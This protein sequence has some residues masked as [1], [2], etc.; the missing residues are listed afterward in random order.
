MSISGLGPVVSLIVAL[1]STSAAARPLLW[2]TSSRGD[3]IYVY[4]LESRALV[5]RLVVGPEPHGI[6]A[7]SDGSV[8][9]VSLEA[10]DRERGELVWIDPRSLEILHRLLVGPEPHQI[11]TTPDGRFVYVPC[12]DGNYWVVDARAR[13]VLKRIATGGRPHN[14]SA[15]AD[16]R[17][18]LLSPMGAPHRVTVVD[19]AAGH[20]VLGEIAFAGSLRPPALSADGRRLFQHVDAL[21]GFQ[22]ADVAGRRVIA[23]ARHRTPLGWFLVH[24][25]LGWLSGQ[26]LARCHGLAIAPDQ[27][28][29][30]SACGAGVTVHGLDDTYPE[31]TRVETDGKGY[32]LTF[33]PDGRWAVV[34]L[35]EQDRVAIIDARRKQVVAYLPTGAGPKR[36]LVLDLGA[37]TPLVDLL[38]P[39]E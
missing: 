31:L 16:G 20:R 15:A 28:E 2:Q 29:I 7:A 8:L 13:Q 33:S 37:E 27:R 14:T 4:D 22:V 10:N 23:T 19:V 9:Y 36:S 26:G 6:T 1:A 12:R 35:S 24:G 21:N 17:L 5:R 32:W 39:M 30:W 34:A 11:A 3:D 38:R 25:K 18:M